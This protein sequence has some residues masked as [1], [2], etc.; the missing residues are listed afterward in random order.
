MLHPVTDSAGHQKIRVYKGDNYTI[1]DAGNSKGRDKNEVFKA[2][3]R[4]KREDDYAAVVS[5]GITGIRKSGYTFGFCWACAALQTYDG[6][7]VMQS[8]PFLIPCGNDRARYDYYKTAESLYNKD[9]FQQFETY[10]QEEKRTMVTPISV[11]AMLLDMTPHILHYLGE[12]CIKI[13]PTFVI[14]GVLFGQM[15]IQIGRIR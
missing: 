4:K 13:T 14:I 6:N 10:G 5:K 12:I 1:P 15:K 2:E 3:N 9:E 7:W 8:A 11:L